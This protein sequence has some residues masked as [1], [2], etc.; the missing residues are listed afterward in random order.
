[1]GHHE[2]IHVKFGGW[3]FSS[4]STGIWSWKC[5]NAKKQIWWHHTSVFYIFPLGALCPTDPPPPIMA[6]LLLCMYTFKNLKC[7]SNLEIFSAL[8]PSWIK[9]S[10]TGNFFFISSL[11]QRNSN[12]GNN[13]ATA[14]KRNCKV[15]TKK[16]RNCEFL[17]QQSNKQTNKKKNHFN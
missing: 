11:S 12:S 9:S 1:M 10:S 2:P 3:G 8:C 4:R 17:A 6:K 13:H 5:W 7:P 16:I 15:E 14:C